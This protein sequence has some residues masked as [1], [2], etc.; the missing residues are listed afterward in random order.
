MTAH[1]DLLKLLQ[2]LCTTRSRFRY[3]IDGLL[4]G[5]NWYIWFDVDMNG[6]EY[7]LRTCDIYI[8][9]YGTGTKDS[10]SGFRVVKDANRFKVMQFLQAVGVDYLPEKSKDAYHKTWLAM[11]LGALE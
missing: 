10:D 1:E 3:V 7:K 9:K 5:E 2:D 4:N 11:K 6:Y 8:Q